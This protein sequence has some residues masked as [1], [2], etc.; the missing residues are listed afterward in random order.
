M[1]ANLTGFA[2]DCGLA[3][4]GDTDGLRSS[5]TSLLRVRQMLMSVH[6]NQGG[7]RDR[8]RF[9]LKK[10][11]ADTALPLRTLQFE[12]I[13]QGSS[14]GTRSKI[15]VP[16]R[17]LKR[18]KTRGAVRWKLEPGMGLARKYLFPPLVWS[19]SCLHIL[20]I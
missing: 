10:M 8:A 18:H 19:R 9:C 14:S 5:R 13:S 16:G 3:P 15:V 12:G 11:R 17:R 4:A 6:Q 7:R 1:G 2:G 20:T